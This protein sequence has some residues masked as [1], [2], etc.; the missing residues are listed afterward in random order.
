MSEVEK[1]Y[2]LKYCSLV[3]LAYLG[4]KGINVYLRRL[5]LKSV[6]VDV[7]LNQIKKFNL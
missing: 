5:L 1:N 4:I 6:L 3:K 7:I 2:L